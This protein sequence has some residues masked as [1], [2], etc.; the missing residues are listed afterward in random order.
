MSQVCEKAEPHQSAEDDTVIRVAVCGEVSAGKSTVMNLLMRRDMLPD[1]VG[2]DN[3]P[4]VF[5][6]YDDEPGFEYRDDQ[7]GF[8]RAAGLDDADVLAGLENLQIW[9]DNAALRGYEFIEVPLTTAQ[10]LTDKDIGLI[11]SADVLIWVT[12]AS[13]AWRLTEEKIVK[14]IGAARPKHCIL[15]VS[16]ADKLRKIADRKKLAERLERETAA[17]FGDVVFLKA[18][19]QRVQRCANSDEEWSYAG[20]EALVKALTAAA[21]Q[22]RTDD[23]AMGERGVSSDD[24]SPMVNEVTAITFTSRRNPKFKSKRQLENGGSVVAPFLSHR[25]RDIIDTLGGDAFAGC[26][27]V[28]HPDT[29][30]V[31]LGDEDQCRALGHVCRQLHS[32]M[33]SMVGG[34]NGH[35]MLGSSMATQNHSII[36]EDV[37]NLG[38]LFLRTNSKTVPRSVAQSAMARIVRSCAVT[39]A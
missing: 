9:Y 32:E 24:G 6:G 23:S 8:V 3:R 26:Y 36:F 20:G 21:D 12:I 4:V 15:A 35:A 2:R 11:R 37:P 1:N 30:A 5:A 27:A 22:V 10:E 34:K 16:R 31:I 29:C 28:G 25:V 17:F 39:A 19:R 7:A 14:E 33:V 13:Q 18:S 38:F